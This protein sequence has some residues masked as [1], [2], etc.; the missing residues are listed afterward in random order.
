MTAAQR[1]V[2]HLAFDPAQVASAT[3]RGDSLL[4]NLREHVLMKR[5]ALPRGE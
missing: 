1:E 2:A 3:A 4:Q 5:F